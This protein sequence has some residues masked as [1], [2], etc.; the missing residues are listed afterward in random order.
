MIEY[1]KKLKT[2]ISDF[3]YNDK[4]E[5]TEIENLIERLIEKEIKDSYKI[6][7]Y[8]LHTGTT[9]SNKIKIKVHFKVRNHHDSFKY[10]YEY[11]NE[12]LTNN[13]RKNK[14]KEILNE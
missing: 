2:I 12:F 5:E 7:V 11:F 13:K 6:N 14:L 10:K 8:F 4:Y 9:L 3:I 1:E